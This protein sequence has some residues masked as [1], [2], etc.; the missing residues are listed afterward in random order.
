MTSPA[1]LTAKPN[2]AGVVPLTPAAVKV[3]AFV[4][5]RDPAATVVAVKVGDIPEP[6]DVPSKVSPDGTEENLTYA[7]M[8]KVSAE[9]T[10]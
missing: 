10:V 4:V 5:V 1:E 8:L 9:P 6:V 2:L 3:P 7:S